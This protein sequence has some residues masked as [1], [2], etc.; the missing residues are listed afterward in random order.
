MS[1]ADRRDTAESRRFSIMLNPFLMMDKFLISSCYSGMMPKFGGTSVDWTPRN[2]AQGVSRLYISL[3]HWLVLVA[4]QNFIASNGPNFRVLIWRWTVHDSSLSNR[5]L[6][7]KKSY[8]DVLEI[9]ALAFWLT[10]GMLMT[11]RFGLMK[12]LNLWQL[13]STLQDWSSLAFVEQARSRSQIWCHYYCHLVLVFL[14]YVFSAYDAAWKPTLHAAWNPL[15]HWIS[16]GNY[17]CF[18]VGLYLCCEVR[19]R[20]SVCAGRFVTHWN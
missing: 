5:P 20:T 13:S 8:T 15:G 18:D 4:L 1:P 9:F 14:L 3:T 10:A 16:S 12:L 19:G 2:S 6:W 7:K 11:F 17:L